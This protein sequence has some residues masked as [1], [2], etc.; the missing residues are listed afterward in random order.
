MTTRRIRDAAQFLV[1]AH[2]ASTVLEFTAELVGTILD[3]GEDPIPQEQRELLEEEARRQA[4]RVYRFLGWQP[5][6]A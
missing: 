2:G 1:L 6:G 5:P 4:L 3:L